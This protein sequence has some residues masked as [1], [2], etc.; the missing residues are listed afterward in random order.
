MK[1]LDKKNIIMSNLY[2]ASSNLIARNFLLEKIK[3]A[4]KENKNDIKVVVLV[5]CGGAGKTT[6]ARNFVND[7]PANIKW[8]I[9]AESKQTTINSFYDLATIIADE[10]MREKLLSI[11]SIPDP[12][13]RTKRVM[14]FV[15]SYLK[16]MGNWYLLFDNVDKIGFIREYFPINSEIWGNG[17]AF[18]TTR[19]KNIENNNLFASSVVQVG[20]LSSDEQYQLFC[21]ILYSGNESV[22]RESSAEIKNFLSKI[23]MFPLDVSSAAYYI[24]NTNIKF[25]DYLSYVNTFSKDFEKIY[26]KIVSERIG[27]DQTRNGI[28]AS[29]FNKIIKENPEFMEMLFLMCIVNSQN[30][31]IKFFEEYKG[32][33]TTQD[34][35]YTLRKFSVISEEEDTFSVHRSIQTMEL[36]YLNASLREVKKC[37]LLN[38]ITNLMIHNIVKRL[39]HGGRLKENMLIPHLQSMLAKIDKLSV[40]TKRKEYTLKLSLALLYCYKNIKPRRFILEF[41]E[42]IVLFNTPEKF[43]E[44]VDFATLLEICGN[45]CIYCG[46]YEEAGKYLAECLLICQK[47]KDSSGIRAI[48]LSDLARVSSI[49]GDF[50]KVKQ[51]MDEVTR[52]IFNDKELEF[53]IKEDIF[54]RYYDC[55]REYFVH[56]DKFRDV[57]DMGI[58]LLKMINADE[59]FYKKGMYSGVFDRSIFL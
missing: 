50:S 21:N 9:N 41:A 52:I 49:M 22:S 56:S 20:E 2:Y 4:I 40:N 47:I 54:E 1:Y 59:F 55:Y 7:T 11:K 44:D 19:N 46:K 33:I 16:Q 43:L 26:T 58:S 37:E 23:P 38:K 17:V 36:Q 3:A 27:Y 51:Y 30:I 39:K 29:I 42:K 28:I 53:F 45:E 35:I 5:G 48:C 13:E 25:C 18:I 14:S 24:K 12:Q 57:I 15:Q 10:Q 34:F 32:K 6:I 8:K 31:P